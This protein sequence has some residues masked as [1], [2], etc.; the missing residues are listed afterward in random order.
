MPE[1]PAPLDLDSLEADYEVASRSLLEGVVAWTRARERL[2][3]AIP[4]LID[5]ARRAERAME[6]API[7]EAQYILQ[8][9]GCPYNQGTG[10][11]E[12]GCASEPAC[13][14]SPPT[15]D[16]VNDILQWVAALINPAPVAGEEEP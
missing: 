11:C 2:F 9:R 4:A 15:E 6:T 16:D 14:T 13:Q 10:Q 8:C 1:T 3:A 5:A 7:A 12:S